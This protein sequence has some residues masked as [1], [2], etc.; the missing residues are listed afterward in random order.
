MD[1]S[2]SF[3]LFGVERV[4]RPTIVNTW[5]IVIFLSIVFIL[6]GRKFETMSVKDKPKG[7]FHVA[8]I[9]VEAIDNLT[10]QTMGRANI[11]FAPYIATLA[12][13]IA[14]ANLLGL[15][16]LKPPTSDYNVTLT[17]ALITV[18]LI[19]FNS[20]RFNG[21]KSYIK[22]YF[23]PLPFLFPINVLGELATPI[24][25]S[26]RLL[27]N[28]LTGVILMTLVYGVFNGILALLAPLVTPVLHAYFDVFSGLLQ[29]FIF[30]MLTMVFV[31]NGI[32]AREEI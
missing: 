26:F 1:I 9:F 11:G 7:V 10:A 12:L 30:I 31:S 22:G 29:T 25:M 23:E 18:V 2:I 27:G 28:I 19:H 24:S 14:F 16:G 3:D 15:V 6:I 5:L 8:E 32:G 4:I 20:I 21:A 13:F 17:L